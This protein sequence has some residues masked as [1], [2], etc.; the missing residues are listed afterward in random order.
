M[1]KNYLIFSLLSMLIVNIFVGSLGLRVEAVEMNNTK[2][3]INRFKVVSGGTEMPRGISQSGMYQVL[4]KDKTSTANWNGTTDKTA[5]YRIWPDYLD[6]NTVPAPHKDAP[7]HFAQVDTNTSIKVRV[8][9]INST[10]INTVRILPSNAIIKNSLN[11][12][13]KNKYIEFDVDPFYVTKHI[14]VEMNAPKNKGQVLK[15]GL[16]I[17]VNPISKVPTGKNVLKLGTGIINSSDVVMDKNNRILITKDSPYDTLYIP[18]NTIVDGRIEIQKSNF[19]VMGRGMVVGSRWKWPKSNPDWDKPNKYPITPD[20]KVVKPIVSG[21]GTNIS[22]EGITTIHPYHFNFGGAK[23]NTNLKAFGWRH[24]SDGIHGDII[25]GCFTRVN[26]DANYF[27]KGEI[28]NN[29]YWGMNNGAIFQLGW[30][31]AAAS[32]EAGGTTIKNCDVV[33]CEWTQDGG[34]QQNNGIFSGILNDCNS[35]EFKDR[36]IQN[37]KFENIDVYGDIFRVM[38]FSTLGFSGTL[39]NF[40]FKNIRFEKEPY[41]PNTVKNYLQSGGN[42]TGFKF[43]N[44]TLGGKKI[45]SFDDLKPI[46]KNDKVTGTVFK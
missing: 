30:G 45:T 4:I 42:I 27:D 31:P 17:F 20:G 44:F 35:K 40:E 36:V 29:T 7:V 2:K 26:D 15:D 22:F 16:M 34:A 11:I 25:K 19:K 10:N 32:K 1:R 8:N 5:T 41:Y 37:I 33:R 23:T 39:K 24:S 46:Q 9:I 13:K 38:G 43:D 14:L 28:A 3:T 18:S 12:N 21:V 6:S